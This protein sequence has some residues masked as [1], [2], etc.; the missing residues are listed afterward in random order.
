VRALLR[1]LSARIALGVLLVIVFAAVLAPVV[2]P[3]GPLDQDLSQSLKSPSGEHLLGTDQLGRDVLSRLIYGARLSLFAAAVA[4]SVAMVVGIV[5]GLVAGYFGGRID[6]VVMRAT[7]ALMSFPP[8]ILALAITGVLGPGLGNAMVAVG[9]VFAPRFLRLTRAAV[10]DI[11]DA[12]Y[13]LAARSMGV[14]DLTILRRH[15]LPNSLGPIVVQATVT[16][17]FAMLAEASLSYLGLGV[18]PPDASWGSMIGEAAR[19]MSRSKILV[20]WPGVAI[21]LTV[22]VLGLLGDSLRRALGLE[23]RGGDDA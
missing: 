20:I 13:V 14:P 12:E 10:L 2:A 19:L 16:A 3:Y 17:G 23:G 15:V 9:V 11:R 7:D 5:P 6:A 21:T 1:D 18:Q 4:V 8:L 22:L